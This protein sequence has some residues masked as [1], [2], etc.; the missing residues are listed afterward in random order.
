MKKWYVIAVFIAMAAAAG[1]SGC[2]KYSAPEPIP[3][4]GYPHTYPK[5]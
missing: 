5:N 1:L 4:S 2:G 3:G